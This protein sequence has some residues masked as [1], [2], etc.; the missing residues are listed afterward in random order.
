MKK[1]PDLFTT[2]KTQVDGNVENIEKSMELPSTF[3]SNPQNM[4]KNYQN[5]IRNGQKVWETRSIFITFICNP[6]WKEI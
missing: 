5:T 3:K 6:E 2:Y 1:L 4:A